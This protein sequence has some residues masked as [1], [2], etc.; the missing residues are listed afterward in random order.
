MK[1]DTSLF[2]FYPLPVMPQ[3]ASLSQQVPVVFYRGGP[4][5]LANR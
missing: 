4:M 2:H 3:T 1:V 5:G